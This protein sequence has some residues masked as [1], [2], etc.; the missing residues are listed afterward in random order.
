M[1]HTQTILA[2]RGGAGYQQAQARKFQ[3]PMQILNQQSTKE[4]EKT[5]FHS[6]Q[7][8][9]TAQECRLYQEDSPLEKHGFLAELYILSGMKNINYGRGINIFFKGFNETD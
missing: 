2:N 4:T 6:A 1:G 7:L 3:T 8:R 9:T 5:E